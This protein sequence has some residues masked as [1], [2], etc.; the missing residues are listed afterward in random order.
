MRFFKITLL[1]ASATGALSSCPLPATYN[2]TSTGI[3]AEPKNGIVALRDPTHVMYKGKHLVYAT[4]LGYDRTWGTVVFDPFSDWSQMGSVN[5]TTL[6]PY[7]I[8]PS[9]F[10][11]RPKGIWVMAYQWSRTPFSYKTSNDPTDLNGWSSEQVLFTGTIT[12]SATGPMHP[13]LIGDDKSMY[14]F[15][16]ADNGSLYRASMPIGNFP[17]SF[18]AT[19]TVVIKDVTRLVFEAVQV[20][21]IAQDKYLLIVEAIGTQGRFFRSF[22]ATSLDGTWT[23]QAST[24]ANPFAGRLNN[25][26]TWTKDVSQGELIRSNPDQTM[27]IDPCNLQFFY[28]GSLP[29]HP[30]FNLIPY[31]FVNG[32]SKEHNMS[33][34]AHIGVAA[35]NS[36]THQHSQPQ[37]HVNMKFA[38]MLSVL[39]LAAATPINNPTTGTD[40]TANEGK[41]FQPEMFYLFTH[42]AF[43]TRPVHSAIHLEN[44]FNDTQIEQAGV[45]RNI[46]AEAT[47]CTLMWAQAQRRNRIFISKGDGLTHV[48]RLSGWPEGEVNLNSIVP[49]DTIGQLGSPEFTFWDTANGAR[50]HIV[51]SF[52]CSTELYFKIELSNVDLES[53]LYFDQDEQN[54]L[55]VHYTI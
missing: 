16:C 52:P 23:P 3:L 17:G 41:V 27:T 2:W 55:Y 51:G 26:A 7:A 19:S 30:E 9:L 11:F 12:N 53:L 36:P 25:N 44:F 40:N 15:F 38:M 35:S 43:D 47:S 5:Q 32:R 10:F 29:D 21:K 46:P 22:T 28:Q 1:L 42:V 50:N 24:E 34:G 33:E 8:A 31:R 54:G 4:T 20:Y 13:A 49:F 6:T 45:F 37:G 48:R 14:L 18:G 39:G